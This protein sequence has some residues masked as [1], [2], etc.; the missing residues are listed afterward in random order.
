MS[1][2]PATAQTR[3]PCWKNKFSQTLPACAAPATW[4]GNPES[5]FAFD[6][7]WRACLAHRVPGDVPMVAVP[8]PQERND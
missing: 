3:E 1:R 6:R 8:A 4:Q 5:P 7:A 2:D